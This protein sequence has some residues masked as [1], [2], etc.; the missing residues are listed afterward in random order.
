MILHTF[1][2]MIPSVFVASAFLHGGVPHHQFKGG[3]VN[4][5]YLHTPSCH[6]HLQYQHKDSVLPRPFSG[7]KPHHDILFATIDASEEKI[8]DTTDVDD[9]E[10]DEVVTGVT[11][12]MAFDSSEVWGVA[13]ISETKSELFTSP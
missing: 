6:R 7:Y 1:V 10:E 4:N 2:L 8:D 12:K 3:L 13:D 11:L 5:K 9:A